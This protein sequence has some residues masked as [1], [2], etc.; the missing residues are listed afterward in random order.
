MLEKDQAIREEQL[1]AREG[2]V[3]RDEATW[4]ER[5]A[6]ANADLAKRQKKAQDEAD[7]K[8]KLAR[9]ELSAGYKAKLAK[10]EERFVT[11]RQELQDRIESLEKEVQRMAPLLQS[12]Q[13]AQACAETKATTLEQDLSELRRQ[14]GPAA[15]LAEQARDKASHVRAMSRQRQLMFE[16]LVRRVRAVADDLRFEVPDFDAR[17]GDDGA[18]YNLF[19]EQFLGKIE[20]IAK[21]FDARVV[22]E[23]RDLLVIATCR[24]FSNL[25]RLHPSIDL[26]DV[27]GHVDASFR[28]PAMQKAAEAYAKKFDQAVVNK[29]DGD[30]EEDA[31]EEEGRAAAGEGSSRGAQA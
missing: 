15:D 12:A 27:T 11:K 22:E 20:E 5:E 16:S 9:E 21:E 14:V 6:K 29:D 17:G 26:E 7:N 19:F 8:V 1:K 13:E 18:A 25:K 28:T 4:T 24:I 30:D 31:E 3:A 10:Q 2:R 23:S